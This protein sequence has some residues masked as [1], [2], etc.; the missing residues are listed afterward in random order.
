MEYKNKSHES[1][2]VSLIKGCTKDGFYKTVIE[3]CIESGTAGD[4][5]SVLLALIL[6]VVLRVVLGVVHWLV[7]GLVLW[8]LIR[9]VL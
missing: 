9:V 1:K 5:G 8:L 4:T 3:G 2:I 6:G 7:W